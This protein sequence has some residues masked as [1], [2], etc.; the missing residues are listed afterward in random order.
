MKVAIVIYSND[1]ETVWNAF[2]FAN[3]CCVYDD[4]TTVFLMGKGVEAPMINSLKFDE[5]WKV[6]FFDFL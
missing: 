5:K 4:D 6:V 1:A 2:R 3:T